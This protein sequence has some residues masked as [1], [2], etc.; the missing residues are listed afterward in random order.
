MDKLEL[1]RHQD[2][3]R[4]FAQ[5]N[6]ES[7]NMGMLDDNGDCLPPFYV[8]TLNHHPSINMRGDHAGE[9]DLWVC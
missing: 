2:D 3:T 4:P 1:N 8:D 6:V 9:F 7:Q 5:A